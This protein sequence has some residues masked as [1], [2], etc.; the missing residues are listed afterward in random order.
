MPNFVPYTGGRGHKGD[1]DWIYIREIYISFGQ[2][3]SHIKKDNLKIKM[4]IIL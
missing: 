1:Q 2:E 3:A 4:W